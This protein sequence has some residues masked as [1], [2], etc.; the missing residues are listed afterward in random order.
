MNIFIDV[1][2]TSPIRGSSYLPTPQKFTNPKCGLVNIKNEDHECFKWCMKYHQSDKSNH[3]SRVTNLL[4]VDDKYNYDDME[5]PATYDDI[6]NFEEVNQV[7]IN[8]YTL[9]ENSDIILEKEG[10]YEYVSNDVIYLLRISSGENS[11]YIYIKNFGN[12]TNVVHCSKDKGKHPCPICNKRILKSELNKHLVSCSKF[13][14]DGTCV[15]LPE[16][17]EGAKPFM[18]L[19]NHKNKLERPYI[20]YCDIESTAVKYNQRKN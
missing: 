13:H 20:A 15:K 4:K 11:H 14:K 9:T 8:I 3:A 1:Y 17:I 19:K 6:S 10:R 5:Y 2:E 12:F 7:C 18:Q 16:W